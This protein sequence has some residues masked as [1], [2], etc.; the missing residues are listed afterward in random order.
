VR[1]S[2]LVQIERFRRLLYLTASLR[3]ED[4]EVLRGLS[5]AAFR[6]P[7][8]RLP[9]LLAEIKRMCDRVRDE[10]RCKLSDDQVEKV[11][12]SMTQSQTGYVYIP[13]WFIDQHW[14]GAYERIFERWPRVPV[15]ALVLFE[16]DLYR[17]SPYAFF[18][19]EQ[20]LLRDVRTLWS[21]I[22]AIANDGNT[23][24]TRPQETQHRLSSLLRTCTGIVSHFLE[25]YLNGLAFEY[26]RRFHEVLTTDEHDFL[27][28]WNSKT[29]RDQFVSFQRK[30]R[31]YPVVIAKYAEV[32]ID[33]KD[34]PDLE[35]LVGEGKLFRDALTHP[36]PRFPIGTDT[37]SKT[38]R[39][40]SVSRGDVKRLIDAAISYAAKVEKALGR[41]WLD[42]KNPTQS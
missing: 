31:E 2:V 1:A 33:L 22:E 16:S 24:R 35:Y 6:L 34:D 40:V 5:E 20:M 29:K 14:F 28:E 19:A 39:V 15:H 13:K 38:A 3:G 21:D 7:N 11:V 12:K 25:A 42:L 26:G 4:A 23:F 36:S 37:I 30:L 10:T 41:D 27:I 17:T 9:E 18:I 8:H 32:V